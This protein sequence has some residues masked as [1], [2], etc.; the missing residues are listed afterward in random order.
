MFLEVILACRRW[1]SKFKDINLHLSYRINPEKC[2]SFNINI[3]TS[4]K[5][6]VSTFR[7][8]ALYLRHIHNW[9]LQLKFNKAICSRRL[10]VQIVT[11]SCYFGV[12]VELLV[13]PSSSSSWA[14]FSLISSF[15]SHPTRP[16]QPD[17][18]GIVYVCTS[19]LPRKLQILMCALFNQ[20]RRTC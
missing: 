15:S 17:P 8:S 2:I 4:Y 6:A 20:N 19:R 14:E 12:V 18:T 11:L 1:I 10:M 7:L 5:T 16:G 13:L 3:L 9:V